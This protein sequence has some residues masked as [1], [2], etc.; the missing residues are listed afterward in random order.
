MIFQLEGAMKNQVCLF[1]LFLIVGYNVFAQT[2]IP[3]GDVYGTW[4]LINSPYYVLGD[5]TVPNDSTL[6]IEPGVSIVFQGHYGL[7]VQGRLLAIGTDN[8]QITFTVNDTIGFYDLNSPLGGW[9]GIRFVS[10]PVQND[11]SKI[12]YCKFEYA[13]ALGTDWYMNAGGAICSIEF[14]KIIISH[15]YFSNCSATRSGGAIFGWE[16][17]MS[18]DNS[19]FSNNLTINYGGAIRCDSSSIT[20]TNSKFSQNG[21]LWGGGIF[22]VNSGIYLQDCSFIGNYSEHGGAIFSNT[23]SLYLNNVSF[24][25]NSSNFG[26]GIGTQ[27][28]NVEIDNSFFSQNS[29][30]NNSGGIDYDIIIPGPATS[31]HFYLSN[32]EFIAN[33][34]TSYYGAIKVLQP[35]TGASLVNVF[36]DKCEFKNNTANRSA[37]IRLDGNMSDFT[38]SNSLFSNN[39]A[40]TQSACT[41][42]RG[43]S[44][45]IFNCLFNSNI[46]QTGL[47]SLVLSNNSNVDFINCTIANN[48]GV[49]SGGLRLQQ[50]SGSK[51]INSIFWGNYPDQISLQSP[52][53]T[54]VSSLYL[55]YNNI[56][57]GI[58]SIH[59]DTISAINYGLGNIDSDPLFVDSLTSDYHLQS[60]SPCIAT[61]IDS[62]EVIGFWYHCPSTDIEGKPRPYPIGTMPDMGAY[63]FQNLVVVRDQDRN[64]PN[65]YNLYQNYPNPFNPSTK[66]S[67]SILGR[68]N[69]SLKIFNLL[70]SEVVELVNAMM[71]VG[72]YD[73]EFNAGDLPSGVYFYQL[74]AGTFINTKKMLLLK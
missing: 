11:T 74:K 22:N 27:N 49:T 36:I 4:T 10:T 55:D 24:E 54:S 65:E 8:R 69:V 26:G 20:I 40:S 9:Y 31:Y 62:I 57:Y 33:T 71:D 56:Q 12:T 46:T 19:E 60:L 61:G 64:V 42:W 63:E 44:G 32:S 16:S 51:V 43:A 25:Q 39:I 72:S 35:E 34:A 18:L 70:G 47:G 5:I 13:K 28:T 21:A 38:I 53:D 66:I 37:A 3:S 41:F 48:I 15:S 50:K 52:N 2:N 14:D 59:I 17:N 23:G 7:F 68:T 30:N 58:D 67:Y 73:V 6:F 45:K 29:A 1:V